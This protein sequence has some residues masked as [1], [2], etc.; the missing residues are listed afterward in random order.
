MRY[1]YA[2]NHFHIKLI[3][4]PVST[5]MMLIKMSNNKMDFCGRG[6]IRYTY[7]SIA[8]S[9]KCSFVLDIWALKRAICNCSEQNNYFFAEIMT[10]FAAAFFGL[11]VLVFAAGAF[12]AFLAF[13][14]A[15]VSVTALLFFFPTDLAAAFF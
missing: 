7:I 14:G 10:A 4:R 5:S 13:D 12:T 9:R 15:F 3:K 6:K 1:I 11:G 8:I 2:N